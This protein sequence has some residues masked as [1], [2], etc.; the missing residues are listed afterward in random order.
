MIFT[1]DQDKQEQCLSPAES[2]ESHTSE[3]FLE[4]Q[5][6]RYSLETPEQLSI[7]PN[8]L[9]NTEEIILVTK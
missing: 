2:H 5:D 6:N 3:V 9:F 8:K 4:T 7:I 1:H